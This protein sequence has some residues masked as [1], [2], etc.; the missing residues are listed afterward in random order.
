M[1]PSP[2]RPRHLPA[3]SGTD[4][5]R[6]LA[7]A[8][9][10]GP[11]AR[12]YDRFTAWLFLGEWAR[13]QRVV[14]PHLPAA[15]LVVELGAGTA[16]LARHAARPERRW[17]ALEPSAAML[18]V[19]RDPNAGETP[20]LVR[21]SARAVPVAD[22]SVD[23]VVATFPTAYLLDPVTAREI[24]RILKPTGRLIVVLAGELAPVGLRR[25]FRRG[26]LRLFYGTDRGRTP[27]TLD[28]AGLTGAIHL[29]ETE[30]GRATLY[31]GA[32]GVMLGGPGAARE[33]RPA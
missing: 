12:F 20:W 18:R 24:R 3:P 30:Y 7:F 15:G 2:H 13:W 6:T 29:V 19:A 25:R 5:L 33:P 4:R 27:D 26:A 22:H 32:L 23:A 9:L 17:L 1:L 8:A 16:A 21:A 28:L 31:V 11:A 10:Y 14:L